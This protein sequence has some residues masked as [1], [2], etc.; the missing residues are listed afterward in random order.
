MA[1]Q[2]KTCEGRGTVWE[3]MGMGIFNIHPCPDCNS[4]KYEEAK[5]RDENKR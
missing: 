3:D 1:E 2:C 5:R 4:K